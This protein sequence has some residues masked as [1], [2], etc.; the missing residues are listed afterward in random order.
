MFR[1]QEFIIESDC[2]FHLLQGF[3]S[4]Y[5]GDERI[6]SHFVITL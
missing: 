1:R 3:C 5:M 4:L 2:F 6:L